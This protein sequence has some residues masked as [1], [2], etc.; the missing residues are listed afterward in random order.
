MRPTNSVRLNV[1]EL[2]ARINPSGVSWNSSL[3]QIVLGT[4]SGEYNTVSVTVSGGLITLS[5]YGV[6][7]FSYYGGV[8]DAQ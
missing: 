4:G 8:K 2:N 1:E 6:S 7:V 5:D 3:S